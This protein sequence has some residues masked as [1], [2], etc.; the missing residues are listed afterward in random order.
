MKFNL[1]FGEIITGVLIA[2]IA[3]TLFQRSEEN[4]RSERDF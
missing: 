2:F 4:E 1:L 3:W